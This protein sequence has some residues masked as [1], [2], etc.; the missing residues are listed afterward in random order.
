MVCKKHILFSALGAFVMLSG[1]LVIHSRSV[2]AEDVVPITD[3]QRVLITQNCSQIKTTLQQL[4][5]SDTLTR[6]NQGQLYTEVS[7]NLMNPM[8]QRITANRYNLDTLGT[9]ASQFAT[10]FATFRAQY[11]DYATKL[12]EVI[13]MKCDNADDFYAKLMRV[14]QIRLDIGSTVKKM[15]GLLADYRTQLAKFSDTQFNATAGG[16]HE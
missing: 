6:V 10:D 1:F 4:S 9:S 15:N 16:S 3:D 11:S 5:Y 12:Q 2:S 8:N 13:T 14:R 7:T